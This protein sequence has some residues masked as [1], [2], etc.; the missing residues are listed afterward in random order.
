[1]T[2]FKEKKNKF[3]ITFSCVHTRVYFFSYNWE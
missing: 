1:M 2:Y 3:I